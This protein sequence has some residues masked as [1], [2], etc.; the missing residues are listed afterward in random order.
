MPA[1]CSYTYHSIHTHLVGFGLAHLR[2]LSSGVL[3]DK[4]DSPAHSHNHTHTAEPMSVEATTVRHDA[5]TP[6]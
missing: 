4:A 2:L 3:G 6:M 5:N 1:T